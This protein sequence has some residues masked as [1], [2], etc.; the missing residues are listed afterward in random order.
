MSKDEFNVNAYCNELSVSPNNDVVAEAKELFQASTVLLGDPWLVRA[1][2][3]GIATAMENQISY[4]GG[5]Y[6]PRLVTKRNG[7]EDNGILTETP[8][9]IGKFTNEDRPHIHDDRDMDMIASD[10]DID[11]Q[12]CEEKMQTAAIVYILAITEHDDV[13]K[14]LNQLSFAG[15]KAKSAARK[16]AYAK[17]S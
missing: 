4:L 5:D 17:A 13:S 6:K 2:F 16:A 1:Y 8:L 3:W 12:K 7:I 14:D 9:D 15:I 10:A 11:I